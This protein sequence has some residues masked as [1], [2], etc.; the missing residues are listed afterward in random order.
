MSILFEKD[1]S[2]GRIIDNVDVPPVETL[3]T[4]IAVQWEEKHQGN[5]FK[6]DE[7]N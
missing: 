2:L 5:R 1:R 4:N 7:T 3:T 6:F